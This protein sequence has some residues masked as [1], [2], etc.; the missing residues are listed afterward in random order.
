MAFFLFLFYLFVLLL[1][2]HLLFRRQKLLFHRSERPV[3][4]S[5]SM[6][7][8]QNPEKSIDEEIGPNQQSERE[9]MQE[10]EECHVSCVE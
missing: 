8:I 3:P 6:G 2:V 4:V 7:L 1:C 5:A 9:E 10:V